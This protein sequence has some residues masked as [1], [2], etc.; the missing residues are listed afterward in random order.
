MHLASAARLDDDTWDELLGATELGAAL[1][2]GVL[3]AGL[4]AAGEDDPPPPPQ[5]VNSRTILR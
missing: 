2:A 1:E 4:D 5:A 3:D